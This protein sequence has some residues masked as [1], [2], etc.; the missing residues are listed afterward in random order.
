MSLL[1]GDSLAR[2]LLAAGLTSSACCIQ[3]WQPSVCPHLTGKTEFCH[4]LC[5]CH[6][7]ET[8]KLKPSVSPQPC[9]KA[10]ASLKALW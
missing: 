10:Q 6:S 9:L 3:L 1:P 7:D 8:A 4:L 5:P 2:G